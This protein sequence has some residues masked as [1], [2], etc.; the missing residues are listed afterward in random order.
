LREIVGED[1]APALLRI[2]VEILDSV[3]KK[4]FTPFLSA[5]Q[6]TPA[7]KATNVVVELFS[8]EGKVFEYEDYGIKIKA[9]PGQ[10]SRANTVTLLVSGKDEA[11][12]Q[13]DLIFRI[14]DHSLKPTDTVLIPVGLL[15]AGKDTAGLARSSLLGFRIMMI[16]RGHTTEEFVKDTLRQIETLCRLATTEDFDL[17][18]EDIVGLATGSINDIITSIKKLIHLLPIIPIDSEELR[19]I[20]E[21]AKEVVTAA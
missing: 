10:R 19:L 1:K 13:Q 8:I 14:G 16:A 12:G 18:A 20:Y 11:I 6:V 4:N 15:D 2:P 9:F 7:G 3:G 5:L 21:R 17:S